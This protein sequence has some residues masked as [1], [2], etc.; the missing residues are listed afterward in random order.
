MAH[1]IEAREPLLDHKLIEFAQQIPALYKL[2]GSQ[3][4]SILKK[5]MRGIIP[6]EIIHRPKQGF[7]VPMQKWFKEDLRE[8]VMD[9]LTDSRTRQRGYFDQRVVSE[10]LREHLS[11]RRDNSR[12][13]W[14]LLMLELWHRAFIDHQPEPA[15][16][17]AKKLTLN[18]LTVGAPA[19]TEA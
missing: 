6:D 15:F 11:G 3:T 7:G 10:T 14:S 5:A 1:S 13:L 2:R 16:A 4:K 12:H 17:G 18:R 19:L 9:T 8:M